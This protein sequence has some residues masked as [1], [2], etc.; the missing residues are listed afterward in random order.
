MTLHP[1]TVLCEGHNL[2]PHRGSLGFVCTEVLP[3]PT[4]ESFPRVSALRRGFTPLEVPRPFR[5]ACRPRPPPKPR[6]TAEHA[7]ARGRGAA[8]A[9]GPSVSPGVGFHLLLT[10]TTHTFWDTRDSRRRGPVPA[11]LSSSVLRVLSFFSWSLLSYCFFVSLT[12]LFLRRCS[13]SEAPFRALPLVLFRVTALHFL[14][15]LCVWLFYS[16]THCILYKLPM[17]SK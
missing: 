12:Y 3:P 16:L 1:F 9:F 8:V 10:L 7:P 15:L 17:S 11:A 2:S 5:L 13:A 4:L 14:P 6:S